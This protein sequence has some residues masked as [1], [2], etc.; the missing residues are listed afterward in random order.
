MSASQVMLETMQIPTCRYRQRPVLKVDL[1]FN[2]ES[3]ASAVWR[4]PTVN[5][6]GAF[7]K[8][9]LATSELEH[10][11]VAVPKC[12]MNGCNREGY[13]SLRKEI[14]RV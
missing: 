7:C 5:M 1:S 10:P 14:L 4:E 12:K 3:R 9:G 6:Q 2:S 11:K 8:P 13:F